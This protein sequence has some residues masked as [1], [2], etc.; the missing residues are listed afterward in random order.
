MASLCW[1]NLKIEKKYDHLQQL[2]KISIKS[3]FNHVNFIV[4]GKFVPIFQILYTANLQF[5]LSCLLFFLLRSFKKILEKFY[6]NFSLKLNYNSFIAILLHLKIIL[7]KRLFLLF[8]VPS[9]FINFRV[10]ASGTSAK[11]VYISN[12]E[13]THILD[14]SFLPKNSP[15]IPNPLI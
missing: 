12:R 10:L 1:S 14:S 4:T 6:L 7:D 13:Q 11:Q 5:I 15:R 2:L 3:L 9:L 8:F